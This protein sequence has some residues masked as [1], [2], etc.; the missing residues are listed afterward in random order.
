MFSVL[1]VFLLLVIKINNVQIIKREGSQQWF[2]KK[3]KFPWVL[4]KYCNKKAAYPCFS[5]RWSIAREPFLS[6][7]P[8]NKTK[9]QKT[10]LPTNKQTK[11]PKTNKQKTRWKK[12]TIP[13]RRACTSL[14][15]RNCKRAFPVREATKQKQQKQ[16]K[17]QKTTRT[18]KQIKNTHRQKHLH[19]E[20][21][22]SSVLKQI[23][24]LKNSRNDC[25][26]PN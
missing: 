20:R 8:Q 25:F 23:I 26:A 15:P 2:Y 6:V 11:T 24:C 9:K 22:P 18:N 3:D 7:K 17:P 12:N 16:N 10:P 13:A 21:V 14:L 1:F 5:W 4:L 19:E